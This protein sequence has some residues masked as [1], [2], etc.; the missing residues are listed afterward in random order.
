MTKGH[1]VSW[2]YVLLLFCYNFFSKGIDLNKT[3]EFS[4]NK[5]KYKLLI[6]ILVISVLLFAIYLMTIFD[7]RSSLY[8]D[9]FCDYQYY[10]KTSLFLNQGYESLSQFDNKVFATSIMPYHFFE[11][12]LS[13]LIIKIFSIPAQISTSIIMPMI[14]G[15]I[16]YLGIVSLAKKKTITVYFTAILL[17]FFTTSN[18]ISD[19]LEKTGYGIGENGGLVISIIL[20]YKTYSTFIFLIF[21]IQM[22][23]FKKYELSLILT[24]FI[25]IASI[26][27]LPTIIPFVCLSTFWLFFRN[28]NKKEFW[29]YTAFLFSYILI[30]FVYQFVIWTPLNSNLYFSLFN[31]INQP[32]AL[33]AIK[34]ILCSFPVIIF[35]FIFKQYLDIES[36]QKRIVLYSFSGLVFMSIFLISFLGGSYDIIQFFTNLYIPLVLVV[37]SFALMRFKMDK[38]FAKISYLLVVVFLL[39]NVNSLKKAASSFSNNKLDPQFVSVINNEFEKGKNNKIYCGFIHSS[40]AYSQFYMLSISKVFGIGE[41]IN[42]YKN[43]FFLIGLSDFTA[44]DWLKNGYKG[45][46]VTKE[47]ALSRVSEGTFY[48]YVEKCKKA[49]KFKSITESQIDFI[50]LLNIDYLFIQ[51]DVNIPTQLMSYL[52]FVESEKNEKGYSLYR[53]K[54]ADNI[55]KSI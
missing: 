15:V 12:W 48:Q 27:L 14:L 55:H 29:Y 21:A 37:F 24:L 53:I 19:Y 52:Q 42:C 36:E 44:V 1:T 20:S 54:Y 47:F 41:V 3:A 22:L 17:M 43:N 13:A 26:A 23:Q 33:I 18:F 50:Q 5:A 51:K 46:K 38:R 11:I 8:T 39:F 45:T 49:R 7:G 9:T 28:K 32:F 2:V 16:S 35:T 25:P 4:D 40:T 6:S 10:A 34:I 30:I 31:F